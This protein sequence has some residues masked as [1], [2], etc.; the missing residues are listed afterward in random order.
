[1][2]R[3][4]SK[5]LGKSFCISLQL[6]KNSFSLSLRDLHSDVI[7]LKAGKPNGNPLPYSEIQIVFK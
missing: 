5:N 1:M 7:N 6:K 4:Q 3:Y 2:D